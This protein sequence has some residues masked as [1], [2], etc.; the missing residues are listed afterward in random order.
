[1]SEK[2]L[3]QDVALAFR[4]FHLSHHRTRLTKS[5][6]QQKA[7]NII[8]TQTR[9]PNMIGKSVLPLLFISYISA[10]TALRCNETDALIQVKFNITQ[11]QW[12]AEVGPPG[13]IRTSLPFLQIPGDFA[14]YRRFSELTDFEACLPRDDCSEVIV[15][16][17]P[18]DG[19]RISFDEEP[20][21]I[22]SSFPFDGTN[23]IS[24]TEVGNC[25][26]PTCTDTEAL[27]EVQFWSGG[28]GGAT[29]YR[30]EGKDGG[31]IMDFNPPPLFEFSLTRNLACVPR[32][33]CYTFLIGTHSQLDPNSIT[34]SSSYSVLFDGELVRKSDSWLFEALHFGNDCQP[35]CNQ[36]ES[37][38]EF[39]MF[40][41]GLNCGFGGD[42][43]DFKWNL[44]LAGDNASESISNSGVVPCTN[45]TSS[46][47][48]HKSVC[49]PK[50]SSCSAFR[51]STPSL[52]RT[53][54]T[55]SLAM[56][57]INYRKYRGQFLASEIHTTNLGSCT[58]SDLCDEQKEDLLDLEMHTAATY[59]QW[60]GSPLFI[61]HRAISWAF[62]NHSSIEARFP[63]FDG[64]ISS[65]E[66]NNVAYD[67]D[68]SYKTIECVPKGKCDYTFGMI[69]AR[70]VDDGALKSYTIRQNGVLLGDSQEVPDQLSR[71]W[72]MTP[73][74]LGQNCFATENHSL[75]SGAIVG[76]IIACCI[77]LSI[78]IA[79]IMIC[80]VRSEERKNEPDKEDPLNEN[81]LTGESYIVY[82]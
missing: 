61:D 31:V 49:I 4:C 57:G 22:G 32:N 27:V 69:D 73:L 52:G 53:S 63:T 18:T 46:S 55:Y 30:V 5:K 14:S 44:S 6:K 19:Y 8:K 17:L 60:G 79:L 68:S 26:K 54:A 10:A 1:M 65:W 74:G 77:V 37:E 58:V 81:L 20:T 13:I 28:D 11:E 35:R 75:S 15:A 64:L 48:A 71:N 39:F 47:L 59:E 42:E 43:G 12:G 78:L 38:V 7:T 21:E 23:P 3:G 80:M 40:Q 24:S 67:L 34:H 66:Y 76:I 45:D 41:R 50:G 82:S 16:G 56:D 62:F 36:D 51:I 9:K 29:S 33:S 2:C 70:A 72:I 25:F